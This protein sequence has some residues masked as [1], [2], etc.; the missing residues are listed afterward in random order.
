MVRQGRPWRENSEE[1]NAET[2]SCIYCIVELLISTTQYGYQHPVSGRTKPA[3]QLH[4]AL[5]SYKKYFLRIIRTLCT[6]LFYLAR[7]L[8]ISSISNVF[9]WYRD[10]RTIAHANVAV[11][12]QVIVSKPLAAILAPLV[13]LPS[14]TRKLLFNIAVSLVKLQ[15]SKFAAHVHEQQPPPPPPP[16]PPPFFKLVRD[17]ARWKQ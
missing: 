12:L 2:L 10:H 1:K 7:D 3:P 5:F 16:P 13:T 11:I 4:I 8:L 17:S 14:F 9:R 15:M 6:L